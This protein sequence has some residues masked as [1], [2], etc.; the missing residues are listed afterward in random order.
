MFSGCAGFLLSGHITLKICLLGYRSHP[1]GGGQGIYI[2]YLSKAL[3]EAG[4]EVDVISGQPYPHVDPRVRLIKMPSL[5]LFE[6]G[7]GSLR[8]HHL[9]SMTNII[10]W[11]SKLTGGFAEPYCF[12]RRVNKYLR[13][14][15]KQYD[16]IHDNQSL[17]YGML[18]VQKRQP[19]VTTLHHP[20]TSDLKIALA[21]C[22]KWWEKILIRRW[23]SFL[24]MQRNVVQE[25]NHIVTVSEK[26]QVDIASA[27]NV[28]ADEINLVYNGIDTAEFRAMPGVERN[29]WRIMATASA[30]APLKGLRYLLKAYAQLLPKYPQLEL[31]VVGKPKPGGETEQLMASLGIADKVQFVTGISTEEMVAKY[32]EA[33]MAVVPSIYEGFGLPAGEAMACEVPVISTN[34]GA[35]PEVVGEAGIIVPTA[36]DKAIAD[37]IETLLNDPDKREQLGKAGRERILERFCWKVCAQEMTQYYQNILAEYANC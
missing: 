7:L 2:K 23:H 25:L 9:K 32:A 30:D 19:L 29:P 13:K 5:D 35:L 17:C 11:T 37:A 26:S 36:D 27:F 4:H 15:G 31:L 21:A 1:Y 12:G 8:P 24:T 22:D 6:N 33:S 20:I 14:H 3:V 28:S 16:L 18:K 10:E 34:G